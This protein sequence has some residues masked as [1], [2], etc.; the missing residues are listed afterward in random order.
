MILI[1]NYILIL[2]IVVE[3]NAY[4]SPK[5]LSEISKIFLHHFNDANPNYILTY[6]PK[7]GIYV[8]I[9]KILPSVIFTNV[10]LDNSDNP[11]IQYLDLQ[12]QFTF[13]MTLYFDNLSIHSIQIKRDNILGY[14][15]FNILSVYSPNATGKF[16]YGQ[17]PNFDEIRFNIEELSKF[18]VL[19]ELFENN[20]KTIREEFHK[21]YIKQF[22]VKIISLIKYITIISI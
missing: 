18:D 10:K 4:L 5:L 11:T 22:K 6:L 17:T 19:S 16:T 12:I 15:H 1:K 3:S 13:T 2:F 7:K 9:D 21:S 8:N 20:Y 14:C